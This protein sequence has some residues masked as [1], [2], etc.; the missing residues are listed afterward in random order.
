MET[1]NSLSVPVLLIIFNRPNETEKVL[2]ALKN[3][4]VKK[5]YILCDGPRNEIKED[6]GLINQ[7]KRVV[8]KYRAFFTVSEL[9]FNE[10]LGIIKTFFQGLNWFFEKEE[11][12][13]ILESD[14]LPNN[15]FFI[16]CE[17][18]L[19]VYKDDHR[20]WHVSGTNFQRSKISRESSY[21]FTSIPLIWGWATWRRAWQNYDP[22]MKDLDLISNT[23]EFRKSFISNKEFRVQKK[24]FKEAYS[25]KIQT[26]DYQWT[27]AMKKNKALAINPNVNL[28]SNIGY[29]PN[30][31]HTKDKY[32]HLANLP[33]ESMGDLKHPHNIIW[34]KKADRFLFYNNICGRHSI[35]S[36]LIRI[37]F[38]L[39]NRFFSI[40]NKMA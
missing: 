37:Y 12:G 17:S 38:H 2:I 23:N 24:K 26:W 15:E 31:I 39:K 19:N 25:G 4:K 11:M 16:F 27:Y 1:E 33:T 14:C 9:Y 10:N 8:N 29:G 34:D 35:L 3:A 40:N 5:L 7:T 30:A 21:F 36:I 6:S 20:I 13:I 32:S 28:V 18:M 22:L